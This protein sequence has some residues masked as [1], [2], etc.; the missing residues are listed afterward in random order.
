M[1]YA[2]DVR[3]ILEKSISTAKKNNFKKLTSEQILKNILIE[4]IP[5]KNSLNKLSCDLSILESELAEKINKTVKFDSVD[6][7]NT[8]SYSEEL[9]IALSMAEI[10]CFMNGRSEVDIYSLVLG[11][12]LN[13][14]NPLAVLLEHQHIN[15]NEFLNVLSS[16]IMKVEEVGVD[17]SYNSFSET[18][19]YQESENWKQYVTDFRSLA[20]KENSLIIGRDVE[21][22]DTIRILCR[23]TKSNVVHVGKPGVGK[24]SI[25]LGLAKLI[26]EDNVPEKLKNYNV[27]SLNLGMLMAG[28]KYRGEFEERITDLLKGLEKEPKTIL[29]IDEI[30]TI[31]GTGN[32]EGGLDLSNLLKTS[33]VNGQLKVIGA[34]TYN[35]YNKYF[36][37]DSA[38]LRRFKKVD[39]VEPSVS[40]TLKILKGIKESYE[41]FHNVSYTE[42]AIK[43]MVE[44][45]VKYINDRYL[46][47]KAI[48]LMDEAGAFISQNDTKGKPKKI[49]R[50]LIEQ[51]VS[52]NCKIPV[53]TINTN[54]SSKLLKLENTLNESVYGQ[55][56]AIY[57]MVKAIKLNRSG[58][59]NADKPIASFLLVGPTG[60]GKTEV[61]KQIAKELNI[62]LI[63]YDLSEYKE[64]H[65]IA[66]LI[67]S[68]QGYVG[69]E[70]GGKLIND[71]IEN[72]HCVLLLDEVEKA[73]PS[74]FDVFLQVLD[75]AVMTDG[76]GRKA[77]FKNVI[78]IMTSNAGAT[79]I[80]EKGLGFNSKLESINVNA[81]ESAVKEFFKPEFINRLTSIISFNPMS[82]EMAKSITERELNL[83]KSLLKYKEVDLT[84]DESLINYITD[85]AMSTIYGAREIIRIVEKDIKSLFVDELLSGSLKKKKVSIIL[86]PTP[87]LKK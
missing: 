75:Y 70:E 48:D 51:I 33:L 32:Q 28:T 84:F 74:F 62:P 60:V 83:L 40:D 81:M 61:S 50:K 25:A 34:T 82:K 38:L 22:Q 53:E 30:H 87:I 36:S 64:S 52:T 7:K 37:K 78:I 80:K 66:K 24:T 10:D 67:G 8:L 76:K 9:A 23:K 59:V 73:H 29:Y 2:S 27:Y 42:E 77:D 15:K 72:P 14:Y 45:S 18:D 13:P 41:S 55:K 47:D 12:L 56:E 71:I 49:D 79:S 57:E 1:K 35:E 86:N 19:G 85:K 11:L 54:E 3:R 69:Y 58:L 17:E 20:K 63:R 65:S 21:I 31:I 6:S 46:P 26:N 68:P 43:A 4:S 16:E 44:L 5:F 39:I